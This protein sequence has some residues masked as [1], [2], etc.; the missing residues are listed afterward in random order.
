MTLPSLWEDRRHAEPGPAPGTPPD[1]HREVVVVGGGITGTTLALLLASAG[2]DVVLLEAARLGSGTT[3]RSTAKVS[4]L[5]GTRLSRL[6]RRHPASVVRDYVTANRA[7]LAWV[8][9]FCEEH[10]VPV[11]RRTAV[12]Y[13][14]TEH[15]ARDVEREHR[16]A[17]EAGLPADLAG[18]LGLPFA[19]TA[20]VT[21]PDQLQVD[22]LAVVDAVAAEAVARGAAVHEGVRVLSVGSARSPY[23]VHTDHGDLTA[24][25]LVLATN[26]PVLD[27]G[28]W[29]GRM[30]AHRS[31]SLALRTDGPPLPGMYLS[32]DQP[33][34]SLRD[35]TVAGEHHLLVGGEGHVTGRSTPT[36]A[37][38]RALRT[39]AAAHYPEATETHAWS[40]QDYR[41]SHELPVAGPLLPGSDSLLLAGGFAKWGMTGGV[42]AA[43][44]L[45]G[46]ILGGEVPWA[47]VLDGWHP[48]TLV[49]L[50]GAVAA[51]A[52]V[53]LELGQGWTRPLA[54]SGGEPAEGCGVV[55][56]R[57]PGT[58]VAVSR[59][60]GQEQRV[61]AVCPHLGG[62][63]RWND[64]EQS[65]D[66]PLHGSRFDGDGELLEG[67][68]TRGL[69]PR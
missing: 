44:A 66:C 69:S 51:N 11:D 25:T 58:P 3:G 23:R 52:L 17:R 30:T 5:Q 32:A 21:L 29:F 65:W 38:L 19:V 1:G 41:T 59:V 20:A 57:R 62:V 12:T 43:V 45:S 16:V 7:G 27:R 22:P 2:V 37:H 6:R 13:A 55:R 35:A 9:R 26:V 34:R 61:S 10:G 14:T 64:A 42:A 39:W 46:R 24:D 36:S 33:T 40:A 47:R 53:G 4:T 49:G 48:R 31:Y 68:A 18:D 28:G 15:G 54:R 67:P 8:E 56:A 60:A 63:V 50:P